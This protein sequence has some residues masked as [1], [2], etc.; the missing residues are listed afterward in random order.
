VLFYGC[1]GCGAVVWLCVFFQV[2][3]CFVCRFWMY[4][5][6]CFYFDCGYDVF[7]GEVMKLFVVYYWL[8]GNFVG[9]YGDWFENEVFFEIQ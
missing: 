7:D 9:I 4:V 5:F 6:D 2:L 1:V 8:V 3:G